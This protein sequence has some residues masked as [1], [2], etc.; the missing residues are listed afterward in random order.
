VDDY[1][2]VFDAERQLYTVQQSLVTIRLARLTS[3]VGLYKAL[4]GGW[5]RTTGAKD[6]VA[7][8]RVKDNDLV[9]T[10]P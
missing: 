2:P 8:D 5:S 10:M 7:Q 3:R 9:V 1:F 4:G 6:A